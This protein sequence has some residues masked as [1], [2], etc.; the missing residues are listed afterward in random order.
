MKASK[1]LQNFNNFTYFYTLNNNELVAIQRIVT[2][3]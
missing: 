3:F 1:K 2:Y